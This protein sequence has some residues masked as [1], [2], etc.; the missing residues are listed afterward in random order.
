M[1]QGCASHFFQPDDTLYTT[2]KSYGLNYDEL[3]FNSLDGTELY[4]WHIYP[5]KPSKGLLFIAHGNA[6]NISAH[7][8]SW[9]WLVNAGYE[10]FIF[11]YRAYGKSE[12]DS[13]IKG[14]VEDTRAALDYLESYYKGHYFV[15]GQSLGGT[16][17][18]N[19]LNE[20]DNS[21]IR[22]AI[23]DSTFVGFSDIAS[24]KMAQMWITWP[25]QWIPYLSIRGDYDAKDKLK[26]KLPLL[27]LHGSKDRI[28][29]P[30]ASWQLYDLSDKPREFWLVK[31]AQ[32]IRS[33]DKEIIQKDFLDFLDK[34]KSFYTPYHSNMKIYD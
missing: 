4:A 6:Q 3:T 9:V 27:F 17:L 14:S 2:P 11:D 33:L 24:D 22:A 13:S 30:N 34:G 20:R 12:G 15:C 16:M 21:H 31:G 28:I 1:F 18:L 7:F 8:V 29:S 26:I 32:H 23:I 5:Q 10:V 25:F 19:A